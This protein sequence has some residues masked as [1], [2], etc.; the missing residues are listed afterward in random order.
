MLDN[1]KRAAIIE[2]IDMD[3]WQHSWHLP[4]DETGRIDWYG[5]NTLNEIAK[6]LNDKVEARL[7]AITELRHALKLLQEN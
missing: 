4:K 5:D 3:N 1:E 7:E 2:A 6:I